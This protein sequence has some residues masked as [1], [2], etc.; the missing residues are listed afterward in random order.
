MIGLSWDAVRLEEGE[1]LIH[2]TLKRDGTA[3]YRRRWSI[4]K[5][6]QA[7]VVPLREDLV[8]PLQ[9]HQSQ[10]KLLGLDVQKG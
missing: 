6:G 8:L 7:R 5:T 10:M 1:L 9:E 2:K 3:T 4:T